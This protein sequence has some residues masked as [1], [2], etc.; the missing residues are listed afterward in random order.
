MRFSAR[1]DTPSLQLIGGAALIALLL[2]A[3]WL[4][5]LNL[6]FRLL[7]TIVHELCHGLAALL[8]GGTFVRFQ[9]APDGSGLAYTAGGW[10]LLI[11][12]AGYLGSALFGA[13]LISVSRSVRACRA[14]LGALGLGLLLLSLR[15]GV[16]TIF[17][18][19]LAGLLTVIS[20][21]LLGAAFLWVAARTTPQWSALLVMVVALQSGFN[22]FGDLMTLVGLSANGPAVRTDA[23]SMAA[24][25]GLPAILWAVLWA[26]MASAILGWAVWRTWIKPR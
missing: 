10:R 14:V 17:S 21:V 26:I 18:A 8:T 1:T 7:S 9:I 11:M 15:Y 20:G 3:P 22:A 4:G 12:P 23:Q 25:T 16:P 6:P 24:A 19:P 13:L 5:P 2:T